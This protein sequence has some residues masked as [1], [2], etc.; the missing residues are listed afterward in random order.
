MGVTSKLIS[1]SRQFFFKR[2]TNNKSI[3]ETK[4]E[5]VYKK[6]TSLTVHSVQT[7]NE[8]EKQIEIGN[9]HEI[10]TQGNSKT[11]CISICLLKKHYNDIYFVNNK[12]FDG[13][14]GDDM[15]N[16]LGR[17]NI[18]SCGSLGAGWNIAMS[19]AAVGL[20]ISFL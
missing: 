5:E 8:F 2:K 6:L 18:K 19:G 11:S 13:K 9:C 7:N 17:I 15:L 20:M 10:I 16:T 3:K 12:Q 4:I 14:N 1:S